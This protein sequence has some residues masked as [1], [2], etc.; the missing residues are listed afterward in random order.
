MSDY[1]LKRPVINGKPSA[2]WYVC[3]TEGRRSRRQ[4]TGETDLVRARKFM[5]Q[6]AVI[7][8]SP[9]EAFTV[10]D[11]CD[12]YLKDREE[13]PRVGYPKAI[14]NSLSHIKAHFGD[15]P[16]SMVSAATVK[17][18]VGQRRRT[19]ARGK[20]ISDGTI[21]KEL[22]FLRQA[23]KYGVRHSWMTIEPEIALPGEAEPRDRFMT[24]D[25]FARLYFHA[26]PFH[27]RL[28]L[29]LAICTAA[30]GKHILALTWDR[31]DFATGMVRY[32]KGAS[33]NKKTAPVPMNAPLRSI[34]E[35]AYK[36]RSGSGRVVEWNGK[37]VGSVRKAYERACRLAGLED[38][39]RHDLRR[40]AASW[41]LQ[42]GESFD[43]V[44]TM[45]GD[46]V[47][48]TRK[49]YAMFSSDYLVGAVNS[50]AGVR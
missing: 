33:S 49:H 28:F 45:L 50:I 23:L 31:V 8:A 37:P 10:G 39:H 20:L 47:E 5:A 22:R 4:S 14:K 27:L 1:S 34:L 38:A 16:P 30:R 3:W 21:S 44:A 36:A 9:P 41:A 15:L 25:E 48:I 19:K 35:T 13:D 40:T 7:Q 46:S 17:L 32:R 2:T 26:S 29:T 11:L 6:Y 18:Y 43:T 24:R 42:G 12:A